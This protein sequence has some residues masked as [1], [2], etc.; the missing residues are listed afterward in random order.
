LE[1]TLSVGLA[2]EAGAIAVAAKEKAAVTPKVF[3]KLLIKV[4]IRET[5]LSDF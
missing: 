4:F 3:F 5:S 2:I 1:E